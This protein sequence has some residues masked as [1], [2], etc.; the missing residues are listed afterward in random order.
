MGPQCLWE[1]LVFIIG[2]NEGREIPY[3]AM[4]KPSSLMGTELP[5]RVATLRSPLLPIAQYPL[6][7]KEA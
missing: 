1:V 3:I 2:K 6:L 7:C 4:G 5:G